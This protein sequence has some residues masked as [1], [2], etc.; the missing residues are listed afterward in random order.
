MKILAHRGHWREPTEKNTL[1]AFE[2]AWSGGFGI[3]TD[4]RDL[5]GTIVVS[6]D[7]PARGALTFETLLQAYAERGKQTPLALNVKADG[8]Q[9]PVAKCLEKYHVENFFVFDMSVPDSLSYLRAAMPVFLRRS[10]YEPW[11]VLHDKAAGIWLDAFASAWWTPDD[12]RSL[13]VRGKQVAVVSP[14]LHGRPHEALWS[15]LRQLEPDTNSGLLLCTDFP[16]DADRF[17]A[18]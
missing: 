7:P 12:V 8:L 1:A 3:E 9:E 10:E 5:D 17:F 14:E 6:H 18:V 11:T 15:A 2:C 13:H 16:N 4:L